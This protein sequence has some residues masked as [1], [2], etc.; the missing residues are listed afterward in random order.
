MVLE[1]AFLASNAPANFTA[2]LPFSPSQPPLVPIHLSYFLS[3]E[4]HFYSPGLD[5]LL[6]CCFVDFFVFMTNDPSF[7]TSLVYP[8]RRGRNSVEMVYKGVKEK[9]R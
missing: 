5:I 3:L 8:W 1:A 6:A 7:T 4:I 2:P 9:N